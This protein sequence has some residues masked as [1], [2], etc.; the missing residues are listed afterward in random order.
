MTDD[1]AQRFYATLEGMTC[2]LRRPFL[3]TLVYL[4][5]MVSFGV[6]LFKSIVVAAVVLVCLTSGIGRRGLERGAVILLAY[7]L[8]VWIDIA[9]TPAHV[10][11]ASQLVMQRIE[12]RV[13]SQ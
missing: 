10:R 8:A 4:V 1:E 5:V 6:D 13:R 9:P 7:I 11:D 12:M 2:S 3:I